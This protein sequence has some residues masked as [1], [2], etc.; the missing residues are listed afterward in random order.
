MLG[1]MRTAVLVA[2]AFAA[3]GLN[4]SAG[5]ARVQE[6]QAVAANSPSESAYYRHAV[7]ELRIWAAENYEGGWTVSLRR[8]GVWNIK[9]EEWRYNGTVTGVPNGKKRRVRS[10]ETVG[11]GY[12]ERGFWSVT[13]Y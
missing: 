6:G 11:V 2:V 5:F 7:H 8:K 13:V 4:P 12:D 9:T 10:H 3:F 1:R